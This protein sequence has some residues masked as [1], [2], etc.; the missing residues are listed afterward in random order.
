MMVDCA[1][2]P[3]YG[4]VPDQRIDVSLADETYLLSSRL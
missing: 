2:R 4:G 1:T 3:W